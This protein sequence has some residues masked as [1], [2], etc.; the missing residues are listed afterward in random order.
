L[1]NFS[2]NA[3]ITFCNGVPSKSVQDEI[4]RKLTEQYTGTDNTSKV[5]VNFCDNSENAPK[6]ERLE[7]DQFGELYQSLMENSVD[8]VYQA[9]RINP[10]LLGKNV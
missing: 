4:Y 9:C 3:I 6:I 2:S 8:D 10:S 5:F 7:S 1:N